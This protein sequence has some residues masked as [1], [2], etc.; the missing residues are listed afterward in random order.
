MNTAVLGYTG[1]VGSNIVKQLNYNCDCYNTSNFEL[2]KGR[3]YERVYCA[4]IPGTKWIANKEPVKDLVNIAKIISVLDTI[5]CEHFY[6]VSSQDCNSTLESDEIYTETPPTIYG[7]H[8]LQFEWF[9]KCRFPFARIMRIGC[10]FGDGLKKNIIYDLI[11]NRIDHPISNTTY[12]LYCIDNI[13]TDFEFMDSNN[14]SIMNRFSNPV[15]VSEIAGI[16]NKDIDFNAIYPTYLN[17]GKFILSKDN[18]LKLLKE[19]YD[20]YKHT[21]C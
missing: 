4:C 3:K 8:R 14:V 19:W 5:E 7:L 17:T 6:L 21:V 11:N 13:L 12:Q 9:I 10:L 2:I 18:E 15:W 1:F 16:L 20:R